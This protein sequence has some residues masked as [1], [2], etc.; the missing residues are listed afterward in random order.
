MKTIRQLFIISSRRSGLGP[1]RPNPS[2]AARSSR[3]AGCAR[4]SSR[5]SSIDTQ[6]VS[7]G[8]FIISKCRGLFL[9]PLQKVI[10]YCKMQNLAASF[11][12][13]R[14]TKSTVCHGELVEPRLFRF[15]QFSHKFCIFRYVTD[16][17]R[18]LF[19]GMGLMLLL[20]MVS[21][22]VVLAEDP[23]TVLW[24][25]TFGG[26]ENEIGRSIQPTSDGGYIITGL[27]PSR[28]GD[29]WFSKINEEGMEIW[30]KYLGGDGNDYGRSVQETEDGG[31]IIVGYTR[32]FSSYNDLWL[33]K[34]DADGN[35]CDYSLTGECN[36]G[37]TSWVRR[38]GGSDHEWGNSVQQ[39]TDG[40]YI[41]TGW[42]DSFS[43]GRQ[44][45]LIKTNE[46][47]ELV[48][49]DYRANGSGEC[50]GFEGKTWVRI[51]GGSESDE[52]QF[53]QQTTDGGYIIVGATQSYGGISGGSIWLIKTNAAGNICDYSMDFSGECEGNGSWMRIYG[54]NGD[55]E[56]YSVQEVN[57]GY[58]LT[59]LTHSY[60]DGNDD[61]WLIKTDSDGNTC[62]YYSEGSGECAGGGK[63]VKKFGNSD[64][65][66]YGKSVQQTSDGGYFISGVTSSFINGKEMWLI[67]TDAN[68]NLEWQKILGGSENDEALFG[69]PTGQDEYI[70]VGYTLSQGAGNKDV[71]VVKLGVG[72]CV[73]NDGDGYLNDACV[74]GGNDCD[75]ADPA[76]NPGASEICDGVD[77]NCN[78]ALDEA[79]EFFECFEGDINGD[80]EINCADVACA[81]KVVSGDETCVSSEGYLACGDMA[82]ADGEILLDDVA[83]IFNA[84]YESETCD[85]GIDNDCDGL[86]DE[87]DSFCCEGEECADICE[88]NNNDLTEIFSE[89]MASYLGVNFED[90]DFEGLNLGEWTGLACT[91]EI[92][93]TSFTED[94]EE[95][96]EANVPEDPGDVEIIPHLY[97]LGIGV[98]SEIIKFSDAGQLF[99]NGELG[100]KYALAVTTNTL[101]DPGLTALA[102]NGGK[103]AAY[104]LGQEMGTWATSSQI[105]VMTESNKIGLL[106]EALGIQ[107]IGIYAEGQKLG[108]YLMGRFTGGIGKGGE[109]GIVG[110]GAVAGIIGTDES[111][112]VSGML[113]W[114]EDADIYY[115]LY[116]PL[117]AEVFGL[118]EVEGDTTASAG[119]KALDEENPGNVEVSDTLSFETIDISSAPILQ[120]G[121]L[122]SVLSILDP[123]TITELVIYD[124]LIANTLQ[125]Q[126]DIF[127]VA[128]VT[129]NS[130]GDTFEFVA[131]EGV[132]VTGT[133]DLTV[134]FGQIEAQEI[135]RFYT[136]KESEVQPQE[137]EVSVSCLEN[138]YLVS[139][140]SYTENGEMHGARPEGHTC[141][142]SARYP[143]GIQS[144]VQ[145]IC[146]GAGTE[147]EDIDED[148]WEAHIC[149]GGDCDDTNADINPATEE[150]FEAN[151]CNDSIDNDC[152]GRLDEEDSDC[153]NDPPEILLPSEQF[154]VDNF[155]LIKGG[156]FGVY[157]KIRDEQENLVYLKVF[158]SIGAGYEEIPAD[159]LSESFVN[160]ETYS[161]EF[162]RYT[163]FWNSAD[164]IPYSTNSYKENV[165]LKIQACD[166]RDCNTQNIP[167][168]P[169]FILDNR[170][171]DFTHPTILDV[172]V[173]PEQITLPG[174]NSIFVTLR[175][176]DQ[177]SG[178]IHGS[179][180]HIGLRYVDPANGTLE[181]TSLYYKSGTVVDEYT[182]RFSFPI[183]DNFGSTTFELNYVKLAD[184]YDN[185]HIYNEES[186]D[187]V[188]D[189][190]LDS[191]NT[192]CE[193]IPGNADQD[194][195]PPELNS[196]EVVYP[197]FIEDPT[198]A[199][200]DP[201]T[202]ITYPKIDYGE[203]V[204]FRGTYEDNISGVASSAIQFQNGSAIAKTTILE[205]CNGE[206]ARD[207]GGAIDQVEIDI[208]EDEIFDVT[209][210]IDGCDSNNPDPL[211]GGFIGNVCFDSGEPLVGLYKNKY[212][213]L[214]D[215]A[216]NSIYHRPDDDNNDDLDES[217]GFY[218]NSS[219]ND[220]VPLEI[221]N[222]EIPGT[223]TIYFDQP[224]AG[225]SVTVTISTI[226]GLMDPVNSDGSIGTGPEWW[227]SKFQ[228]RSPLNEDLESKYCSNKASLACEE[229]DGDG[230]IYCDASYSC[231]ITVEDLGGPP[232]GTWRF[233]YL[234]IYDEGNNSLIIRD[235]S[236]SVYGDT[237]PNMVDDDADGDGVND[238]IDN[239]LYRKNPNQNGTDCPDDKDND[240][241]PDAV[242]N[243]VSVPN[244]YQGDRDGDGTGDPC[245]AGYDGPIYTFNFSPK[246]VIQGHE[247]FE[248]P[249]G[250]I[251]AYATFE[252]YYFNLTAWY[253]E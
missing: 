9:R 177:G 21:P 187:L 139:C 178:T 64:Q 23:I 235:D 184:N 99:I 154:E 212:V 221:L 186:G 112:L 225:E 118:F 188:Y 193:V 233:K 151:N 57:G 98:T 136:M 78:G 192:S 58:I 229:P 110:S 86:A 83:A 204:Y 75:D 252:D 205:T 122:N 1:T 125:M 71:Y 123:L 222:M 153:V 166:Y 211:N 73:D 101:A 195:V 107:S 149:G 104:V 95:A 41:V 13:L 128:G 172:Y 253:C 164:Q 15:S 14:M 52:G 59:G 162:T 25:K 102:I 232:C 4:M 120:F 68:G 208:D 197:D 18:S 97:S 148:G 3:S 67:K 29:F 159:S 237:I 24:T 2:L 200:T 49:C 210:E 141:Y 226:L 214:T 65:Y 56:G 203:C 11:D 170:G 150:S 12:W 48:N 16:F 190:L 43:T 243:C 194:Q 47:G 30:R 202:S 163:F 239:C 224:S 96:E 181:T 89:N 158:Y 238:E 22:G 84:V 129:I 146:F 85:D 51:L 189:E 10:N 174:E 111:G 140:N 124:E 246:G 133:G 114:K 168:S 35:V 198:R 145:A 167:V 74:D 241:I 109:A 191:R 175:A 55:D 196:F 34:T 251:N 240:L 38:Y 134:P 6:C 161:D 33:I 87:D 17:C 94:W 53:V 82:P 143:A 62:D 199:W 19:F 247:V 108:G 223:R 126:D 127:R 137:R 60:G 131:D 88:Y 61:L 207:I 69:M 183:P 20:F 185:S 218:L 147:C 160:L 142:A 37:E 169:A 201:N 119:V 66:E 180:S 26:S 121:G 220:D 156:D 236:D 155:K 227:T 46:F 44:V 179:T 106:S 135:G 173:E 115:G 8:S 228:Y 165:T 28:G 117:K 31:Y 171:V 206:D 90:I 27:S 92:D 36:D 248:Q 76:I 116:T 91:P 217:D 182:R 209:I 138:D 100:D 80:C 42:T 103:I 234:K 152:D 45:W 77:N 79:D 63:W 72:G 32:S 132:T 245:E 242:D 113:G 230:N 157:F 250:S 7:T 216:W 176:R 81:F 105:D 213:Y 70:A 219:Y 54:G 215:H 40:G 244:P 93:F 130:P 39:T 50:E 249:D 5:R 144:T 231:A